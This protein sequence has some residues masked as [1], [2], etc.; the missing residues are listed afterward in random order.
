M[1][2]PFAS[3][4]CDKY[5]AKYRPSYATRILDVQAALAQLMVF[6][7]SYGGGVC[8]APSSWPGWCQRA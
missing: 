4:M 5:T 2:L 7:K 3:F 8:T 1:D 6:E